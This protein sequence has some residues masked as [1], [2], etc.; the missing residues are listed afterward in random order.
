VGYRSYQTWTKEPGTLY[1]LAFLGEPKGKEGR[2]RLAFGGTL[3][4]G[5]LSIDPAT[6]A[7]EPENAFKLPIRIRSLAADAGGHRLLI[8]TGNLLSGA[9]RRRQYSWLLDPADGQG[10]E[11]QPLPGEMHTDGQWAAV[12]NAEGTLL[13]T[14]GWDG[15][16]VIWRRSGTADWQPR[17]LVAPPRLSGAQILA[18]ALAP[19]GRDLVFGTFGGE[20]RLWR[21]AGGGF[22]EQPSLLSLKIPIRALAPSGRLAVACAPMERYLGSEAQKGRTHL[23]PAI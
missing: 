12:T 10:G 2:L 13:L 1:A 14:A 20:V 9:S 6:L 18:A 16:A 23:P 5:I 15:R 22:R 8:A 11:A 19:D 21:D 4:S 3:D 7:V 17:T